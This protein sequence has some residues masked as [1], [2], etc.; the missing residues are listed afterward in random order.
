MSRSTFNL[1]LRDRLEEL[2][3]PLCA[4][5]YAGSNV[6]GV[7]LEGGD[8]IAGKN[9]PRIFGRPRTVSPICVNDVKRIY[10]FNDGALYN[11]TNV[12]DRGVTLLKAADYVSQADMEAN[13]PAEGY[14][15]AWLA[16]GYIRLGR[17]PT[18]IITGDPVQG[19]TAADRTCAKV[20][21]AILTAAGILP[22]NIASVDL[23][24]LDA[25]QSSEIGISWQDNTSC[26][27]A[28]DRVCRSAG[29]WWTFDRTDL[30]R[31]KRFDAPVGAPVITLTDIEIIDIEPVNLD[32]CDVPLWQSTIRYNPN[33]VVQKS[34]IAS[35]VDITTRTMLAQ[36]YMQRVTSNAAIKTA[37]PL[38][39]ELIFDTDFVQSGASA[40]AENT[41]RFN[42]YNVQRYAYRIIV[43]LTQAQ[44]TLIGLGA[45][46]RVQ[47]DR[48]ALD[49]GKDFIVI[50]M[51]EDHAKG[52]FIGVELMLFG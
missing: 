7:G 15:R 19:A 36:E 25:V 39:G 8:D 37:Y 13:A 16:G 44:V 46:V 9:K 11:I 26:K 43:R 33:T 17:D 45:E 21:N 47:L 49:A 52:D 10:Q 12:R 4:N 2:N 34:D 22:A 51:E 29:A 27:A 48:F 3:K 35:S 1:H 30:F 41:R 5:V 23:T 50:E 18:G 38:A 14:Y 40:T 28:I 32:W 31:I 42:L 24:A 20:I 6:G